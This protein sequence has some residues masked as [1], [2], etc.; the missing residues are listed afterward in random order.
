MLV[1]LGTLLNSAVHKLLP[2]F[3]G[4]LCDMMPGVRSLRPFATASLNCSLQGLPGLVPSS[5]QQT[6]HLL[7]YTPYISGATQ[8]SAVCCWNYRLCPSPSELAE[9]SCE[10]FLTDVGCAET[11]HAN[12]HFSLIAFT[13]VSSKSW[14]SCIS[15]VHAKIILPLFCSAAHSEMKKQKYVYNSRGLLAA[16]AGMEWGMALCVP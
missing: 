15:S 6:S 7:F 8:C 12:V 3:P 9:K 14:P 5:L 16:L 4:N 11:L 1:S 2:T 13:R 10:G